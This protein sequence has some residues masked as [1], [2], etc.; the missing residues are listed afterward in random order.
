ML[1][2]LLSKLHCGQLNLA[3]CDGKAGTLWH[4][5]IVLFGGA[6]MLLLT[7]EEA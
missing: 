1:S 7:A 4:Y 3:L 6:R 2:D 5:V